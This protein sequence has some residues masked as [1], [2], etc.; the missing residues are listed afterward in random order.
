MR[1][2]QLLDLIEESSCASICASDCQYLWQR[3]FSSK[4]VKLIMPLKSY[5]KE[6]QEE[7]RE[8]REE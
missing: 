6:Y 3:Y 4:T 5:R 2:I 7:L 8:K 1:M